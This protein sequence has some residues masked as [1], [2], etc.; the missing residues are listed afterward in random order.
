MAYSKYGN[1]QVT[2][3]GY[4][5]DSKAE[6][7]RYQD[8]K[9]TE[10]AGEIQGLTVHPTYELQPRFRAASGI[11]RPICYEGDFAYIENGRQ[12]VEDVKG[13]VSK[14]FAIKR[15][16]FLFRYPEIDLRIIP[17]KDARPHTGRPRKRAA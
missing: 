12:V 10:Q 4:T 11:I 13:V 6:A 1:V 15:K 8:L 14:E 16:M 2:I 3:D 9:L 7:L 17:A 5:F